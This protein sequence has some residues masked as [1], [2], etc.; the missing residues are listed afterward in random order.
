[1]TYF[2]KRLA[3]RL[4][5]L[6][7]LAFAVFGTTSEADTARACNEVCQKVG[8]YAQCGFASGAGNIGC[9]VDYINNRCRFRLYC[10]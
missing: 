5:L 1:M 3:C 2:L 6:A 4:L 8:G 7:A 9:T 10:A